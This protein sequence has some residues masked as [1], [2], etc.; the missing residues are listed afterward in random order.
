MVEESR[1]VE[2]GRMRQKKKKQQKKRRIEG[3]ISAVCTFELLPK[4]MK[5]LLAGIQNME[6]GRRKPRE[7]HAW[8]PHA[9]GDWPKVA[10]KNA[11]YFLLVIHRVSYLIGSFR[12]F[13][14]FFLFLIIIFFYFF[15]H[16]YLPF[17]SQIYE[18][19]ENYCNVYLLDICVYITYIIF[20]QQF[21]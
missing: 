3:N 10:T 1:R 7:L 21:S 13:F 5:N 9:R 12:I 18:I 11:F 20:F 15:F 8:K 14:Y 16:R 4:N 17:L 2:R 6:N 19:S